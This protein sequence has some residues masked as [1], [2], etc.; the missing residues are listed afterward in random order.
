MFER[1]D[2]TNL[3]TEWVSSN[4]PWKSFKSR[5]YLFKI[6]TLITETLINF[7]NATNCKTTLL[8]LIGFVFASRHSIS[9][10]IGEMKCP[11]VFTQINRMVARQRMTFIALKMSC[12]EPRRLN[13][14]KFVGWCDCTLNYNVL[15]HIR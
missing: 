8:L 3:I 7:E 11:V 15:P 2:V 14:S 4:I 13:L 10:N 6:P 12:C 5:V 1:T 9:Y